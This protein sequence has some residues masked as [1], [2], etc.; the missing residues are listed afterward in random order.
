M[1]K[2]SPDSDT[3]PAAALADFA[4]VENEATWTDWYYQGTEQGDLGESHRWVRYAVEGADGMIAV[5]QTEIRLV[6]TFN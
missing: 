4:E 1:I 3:P 5:L 2:I 6:H